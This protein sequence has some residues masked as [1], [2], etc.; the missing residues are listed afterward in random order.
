MLTI[1]PTAVISPL[2]DIEQSV[3]G[4]GITIGART[5]VDAFVKIKNEKFRKA[6]ADLAQ[7][8]AKEEV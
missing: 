4:T 1:H 8:F 7:T 3:R 2:A 5:Q 6:I